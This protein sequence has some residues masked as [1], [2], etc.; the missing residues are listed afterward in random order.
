MKVARSQR[1]AEMPPYFDSITNDYT[2]KR[3]MSIVSIV[4][5]EYFIRH[6]NFWKHLAPCLFPLMQSGYRG[7]ICNILGSSPIVFPHRFAC[8]NKLQGLVKRREGVC[9][10]L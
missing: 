2:L 8:M 10:F 3:I 5:S 1:R 6:T 4:A 9:Y 7:A